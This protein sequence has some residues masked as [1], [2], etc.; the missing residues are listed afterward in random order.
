MNDRYPVTDQGV[1]IPKSW[2]G[3]AVEVEVRRVNGQ[4]V[5]V[6]LNG[7]L[8]EVDT[9]PIPISSDDPA[10]EL[11]KQPIRMEGIDDASVNLDE[12]H[13]DDPHRT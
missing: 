13:Y 6:P 5:L 12:Y 2:F 3:E 4:L 9:N 8:T 1:T 11:G 10:W 7:A